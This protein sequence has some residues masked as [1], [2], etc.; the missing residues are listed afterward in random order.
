MIVAMH[1]H[2]NTKDPNQFAKPESFAQAM[3]MSKYFKI[4]LD[5]GHFTAAGYDAVPYI[6]DNHE[7][8]ML[9]HRKRTVRLSITNKLGAHNEA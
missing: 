6:Q 8:L 7:N 4:N 9:I 3:A 5:I 1:G 2:S